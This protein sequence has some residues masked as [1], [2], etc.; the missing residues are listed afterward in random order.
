MPPTATAFRSSPRVDAAL[1]AT[2]AGLQAA[3]GA[4]DLVFA[5]ELH[6][7]LERLVESRR[8]CELSE[9]AA[10]ALLAYARLAWVSVARTIPL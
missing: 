2:A 5:R 7:E 4:G 8:G 3:I 6:D 1:T 9:L 10:D